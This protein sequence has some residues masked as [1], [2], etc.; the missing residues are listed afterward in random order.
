MRPHCCWPACV[1]LCL[2]APAAAPAAEREDILVADFEGD[3][4]GAWKVTGEA[5]GKCVF[6]LRDRP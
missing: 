4:Y 3:D 1:L 6:P 2:L 5:F